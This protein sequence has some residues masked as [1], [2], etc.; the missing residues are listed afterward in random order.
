MLQ[1][2]KILTFIGEPITFHLY[3]S[4][5]STNNEAKRRADIDRGIHLYVSAHQTAGRG[6]R[7]HT[8]Y[9]PRDTGLYMTLSLPL[10][11]AIPADIQKLTCAAAVAVCDAVS[12]LSDS[13]PRI[14][15]VNDIFVDDKKA[16]GILAELITDTDNRPCA[17]IVGIGL[18]LNTADFPEE[19]ADKA[20]NFGTIDRNALCGTVADNL[21]TLFKNLNDNSVI[22]KYKAL[23]LCIGR[24][25]TYEKD[26]REHIA[27]AVDIDADGGLVVEENG[28][29]TILHSGEISVK[30]I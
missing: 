14:K 18:N 19:I 28:V 17:V 12:A 8:F 26:G 2:E 15:W 5:D 30:M 10:A 1:Q 11:A 9:S 20:G 24:T 4:I 7:G 16:A 21:I 6:R 3:D 29:F 23:N 22:E 25:V 27:A 13:S